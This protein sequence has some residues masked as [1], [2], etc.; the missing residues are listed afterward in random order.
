M[1]NESLKPNCS[2]CDYLSYGY[3]IVRNWNG[4]SIPNYWTNENSNYGKM[5]YVNYLNESLS[6]DL[7]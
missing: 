2:N 4:Y 7:S 5:S 6:Y 3:W 1:T